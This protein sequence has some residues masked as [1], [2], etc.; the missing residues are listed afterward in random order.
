MTFPPTTPKPLQFADSTMAKWLNDR[1]NVRTAR[2]TR[3]LTFRARDWETLFETQLPVPLLPV[4]ASEVDAFAEAAASAS[5]SPSISVT[6]NVVDSS[7]SAFTSGPIFSLPSVPSLM[8]EVVSS[9]C[10][11]SSSALAA[12]V[13]FSASSASSAC[14]SPASSPHA[15]SDV[16]GPAL[17]QVLST[18]AFNHASDPL[19]PRYWSVVKVSAINSHCLFTAIVFWEKLVTWLTQPVHSRESLFNPTLPPPNAVEAASKFRQDVVALVRRQLS[20]LMD[21]GSG[22]AC[23]C[24][25]C[26]FWAGAW[27]DT[28][29][30][31]R[32]FVEVFAGGIS[33]LEGEPVKKWLEANVATEPD[34]VKAAFLRAL[35]QQQ[36]SDATSGAESVLISLGLPTHTLHNHESHEPRHVPGGDRRILVFERDPADGLVKLKCKFFERADP[37][38][39]SVSPPIILLRSA[40]ESEARE[41]PIEFRT[42][43]KCM[44]CDHV[45]SINQSRPCSNCQ[46]SLRVNCTSFQC[47]C[48]RTLPADHFQ[49][50]SPLCNNRK[51]KVSMQRTTFESHSAALAQVH[52]VPDQRAGEHFDLLLPIALAHWLQQNYGVAVEPLNLMPAKLTGNLFVLPLLCAR[53][54]PCLNVRD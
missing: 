16:M 33:A 8:P 18:W 24:Q 20:C 30:K 43:S 17:Q 38:E 32:V 5:R 40:S 4:S 7:S 23:T 25:H 10:A 51:C 12:S 50:Q 13:V 15:D 1:F 19:D 48:G 44:V 28:V 49:W 31:A 52:A 42:L 34:P 29:D 45:N 27:G 2:F 21:E 11:S 53:M 54:C 35:N 39:S 46:A 41:V 22:Q 47:T 26:N 36:L 6:A 14:C 3:E 9:S 37:A